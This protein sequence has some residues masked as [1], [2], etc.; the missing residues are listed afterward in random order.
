MCAEDL[1]GIDPTTHRLEFVGPWYERSD[2]KRLRQRISG[3]GFNAPH[4]NSAFP[5][6]VLSQYRTSD[7]TDDDT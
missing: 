6:A 7:G 1:I 3:R 4:T 2:L 5:H